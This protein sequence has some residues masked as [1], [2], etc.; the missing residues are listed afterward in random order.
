MSQTLTIPDHLV[1][2]LEAHREARGLDSI[3]AAAEALIAQGL[4]AEGEDHSAGR[5]DDDLRA[6]VDEADESGAS[7]A[8]DA[9]AARAEVLRRFAARN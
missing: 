8:W 9:R 5:S 4:A 6:L 7:A 1:A 2:A 3:E